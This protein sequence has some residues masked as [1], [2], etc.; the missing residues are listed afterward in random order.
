[1]EKPSSIWMAKLGAL[2]WPVQTQSQVEAPKFWSERKLR[3]KSLSVHEISLISSFFT[4]A[5]FPALF[6]KPLFVQHKMANGAFWTKAL[7]S[8]T[9]K[10]TWK[11]FEGQVPVWEKIVFLLPSWWLDNCWPLCSD[12]SAI[13][14]WIG[15]WTRERGRERISSCAIPHLQG[16]QFAVPC[17]K[18]YFCLMPQF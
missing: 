6:I 10:S 9:T 14:R 8:K 1:M 5:H 7:C 18:N 3:G 2:K 13:V 16:R 11:A 4:P 12:G 17:P 15:H